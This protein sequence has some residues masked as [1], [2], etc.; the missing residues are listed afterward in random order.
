MIKSI[1]WSSMIDYPNQVSTILFVGTCNW[2]CEF[3]H[4][5]PLLKLNVI[6]ILKYYIFL[7]IKLNIFINF[8]KIK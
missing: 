3:C 8:S 2:N 4:N 5:L 7:I 6:S 1:I